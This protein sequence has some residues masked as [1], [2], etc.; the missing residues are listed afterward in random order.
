MH[1]LIVEDD[2]VARD[3][4]AKAL[5]EAGHTVDVAGNGL[6]GLHVASSV[7]VDLAI[8]DRMLP[9]LE[10]GACAGAVAAGHG[11]ENAGPHPERPGGRR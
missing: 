8:V 9:K 7:A 11:A 6:E 1:I 2:E 4:L 10:L 3:Y 5:R